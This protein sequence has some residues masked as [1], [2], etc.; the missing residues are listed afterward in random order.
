[1]LASGMKR[2]LF[3]L[4]VAVS[5]VTML[6]IVALWVRSY[7]RTDSVERTDLS[8]RTRVFQQTAVVSYR[9]RISLG[10]FAVTVGASELP[11]TEIHEWSRNSSIYS[12]EVVTIPHWTFVGTATVLP[13]CWYVGR[14]R[15]IPQGACKRC[16]YELR[17]TPE[18]CPECGTAVAPKAAEAAA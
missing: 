14:Q 7:W 11:L 6:A 18:R 1:M 12:P 13:V 9:G 10:R 4:A 15:K 5:L 8:V 17:A 16:G 2:R 3:N